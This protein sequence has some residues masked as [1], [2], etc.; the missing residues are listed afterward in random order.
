MLLVVNTVFSSHKMILLSL[1]ALM[2]GVLLGL[3]LLYSALYFLPWFSFIPLL[4]CLNDCS[5]RQAY[6]FGLLSGLGVSAV[7]C[8]WLDTLIYSITE[9]DVWLR[10]LISLFFW[11]YTAHVMV[12]VALLYHG[13]IKRT[14]IPKE[15]GFPAVIVL[16]FSL[17]PQLFPVQIGVTQSNFLIAMQAIEFTGVYGLDFVIALLNVLLFKLLIGS[18]K[19]RGYILA[20]VCCVVW[21]AY[22]AFCLTSYVVNQDKQID[23]D[24]SIKKVGIIQSNDTPSANILSPNKNYSW[25][26][27]PEMHLTESLSDFNADL[28]VWP[29]SRFKGYFQKEHVAKSFREKAKDLGLPIIIQDVE[30]ITENGKIKK[31]NSSVYIDKKGVESN[32]YRKRELISFAESVPDFMDYEPIKKSIKYVFG[33]FFSDFS[34]GLHSRVYELENLTLVPVIC[35]EILFPKLV[36]KSIDNHLKNQ[37]LLVQSSNVWF[38]N[39]R[40]TFQ[41]MN[42][43]ILR[44]VENRIPMVHVINNGTS[45]ITLPS[46]RIWFKSKIGKV[47]S[48]LVDL[49]YSENY[50]KTFFGDFP[51]AFL[52]AVYLYAFYMMLCIIKEKTSNHCR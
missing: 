49:P 32:V 18:K 15:W 44:S 30:R 51:Y 33:E 45:I 21:F 2:S 50:K 10:W 48:Y 25:S 4:F 7:S 46:G 27:P 34:A 28:V 37:V 39:T 8:Y 40:Q 19:G 20:V 24:L 12:L 11:V 17:Y 38:G 16:S 5:L 1:M 3:S 42:Y 36:A 23:E 6:W 52:Y 31:Y 26:Y 9:Y 35:Y 41:H 29:E 43:S 14:T 47:G 22:G 13:I